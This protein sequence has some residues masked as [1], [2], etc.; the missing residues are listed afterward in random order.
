[1]LAESTTVLVFHVAQLR[2]APAS[3][4]A[5]AGAGFAPG[6]DEKRDFRWT[7]NLG[8]QPLG[9]RNGQEMRHLSWL[10]DSC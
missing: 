6:D 1:M 9:N 8:F 5:A 7:Q 10:V 3:P 2:H 4:R